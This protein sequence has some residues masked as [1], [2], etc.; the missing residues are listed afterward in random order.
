[1]CV[2]R[3]FRVGMPN[4]K[5]VSPSLSLISEPN[6]ITLFGLPLW[7]LSSPPAHL[8]RRSTQLIETYAKPWK[9]NGQRGF[10]KIK[11]AKPI[12]PA[13]FAYEHL[14]RSSILDENQ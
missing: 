7:S 3:T 1:M 13:A 8:L 12:R 9:M 11:L 6:A 14:L 10:I 4:P 5:T 2:E